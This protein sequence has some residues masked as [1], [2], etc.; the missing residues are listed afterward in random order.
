MNNFTK[1]ICFIFILTCSVAFHL[2]AAEINPMDFAMGITINV[3]D[4]ASV[5]TFELPKSVYD[6]V[7]REDLGDMRIFNNENEMVPF[8]IKQGKTSE[9]RKKQA[10]KSRNLPFFPLYKTSKKSNEN[11]SVRIAKD[12]KGTIVN[13]DSKPG[14]GKKTRISSYLVDL[15]S[16]KNKPDY[17]LFK[18]KGK[19]NLVANISIKA[20]NRLNG[21]STIVSNATLADVRFSDNR[22]YKN[23]VDL[24]YFSKKYLRISWPSSA[25]GGRITKI[26]GHF[27]STDYY[28]KLS[29][30]KIKAF[31]VRSETNPTDYEF[32]LDGF[33]P[34]DK[35]RISLPQKNTLVNGSLYSGFDSDNLRKVFSGELYYFMMYGT[36]LK[37]DD[38]V[39]SPDNSTNWLLRIDDSGG[40]IG[41]SLPVITIE[42]HPHIVTFVARGEGPFK[43][44]FGS[45]EIEPVSTRT[46]PMILSLDESQKRLLVRDAVVGDEFILGGPEKLLPPPEP[47]P[48]KK[49][50]LW[51]VLIFGVLITAV[52]ALRL[53]KQMK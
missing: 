23:R 50:I 9:K 44:G 35:V 45:L 38:I 49:F 51:G 21:F 2:S 34:V 30:K 33:Y 5:Y 28:R 26:T 16:F 32:Y 13:I 29:G 27:L 22:L 8:T 12:K 3:D 39:F 14:S 1:K 25:G 4:K 48:L 53:V 36:S 47:F 7:I 43:I 42:Y 46:D 24:P 37:N 11:L 17:L 10:R 40:G 15:S 18:W 6:T 20:S 41:K 31:P 52:M 19:N